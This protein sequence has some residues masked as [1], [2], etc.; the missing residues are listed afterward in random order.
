LT[1]SLPGIAET[2]INQ[3]K[4][5]ALR[6]VVRVYN[7]ARIPQPELLEAEKESARILKEAGIEAV[8]L[9]CPISPDSRD[10]PACQPPSSSTD[11]VL[12]ILPLS[13]VK[14]AKDLSLRNDSLGF[15]FHV[16]TTNQ[17]ALRSFTIIGWNACRVELCFPNDSSWGHVMAH[18]LGHLL[19]GSNSH[20]ER[21]L[22]REMWWPDEL[23]RAARGELLFTR[24][25]PKGCGLMSS[26]GRRRV[27]D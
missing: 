7:F 2:P 12:Q 4:K 27:I 1:L 24:S 6:I 14:R 11:F 15:A 19:P 17:P 10:S 21:D 20:S 3:D 18:E 16:V 22:M 13:K 23:G 25:K 26:G 5:F 8:W 9:D